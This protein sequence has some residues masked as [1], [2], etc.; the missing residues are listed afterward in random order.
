MDKAKIL[1]VDDERIV[2]TSIKKLLEKEGYQVQVSESAKDALTK[3]KSDDFSLIICDVRLP[4]EDG[5][6][7]IKKIRKHL[8]DNGKSEIPEILVTGYADIARYQEAA[9]LGIKDYIHKPFDNKN[10]IFAVKSFL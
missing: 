1:V 3:V 8:K 9:D 2:L 6:E 4:G 5:I 10:L 7:L